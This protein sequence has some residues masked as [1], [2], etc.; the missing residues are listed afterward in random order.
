MF[1]DS[2]SGKQRITGHQRRPALA[3]A[4][5]GKRMRRGID[6][7]SSLFVRIKATPEPAQ[8]VGRMER[9]RHPPFLW[10]PARRVTRLFAGVHPPCASCHRLDPPDPRTPVGQTAATGYTLLYRIISLA[11]AG[12]L[13]EGRQ[14]KP[15]V[16]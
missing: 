5:G 7:M 6:H 4:P 3:A 14:D 11:S 15:G 2:G 1:Y 16:T 9:R 8:F 13:A 12:T 10:R